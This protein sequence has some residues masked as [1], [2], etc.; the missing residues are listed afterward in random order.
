MSQIHPFVLSQEKENF[1]NRRRV[2]VTASSAVP[3]NSVESESCLN[4]CRGQKEEDRREDGSV[5]FVEDPDPGGQLAAAM[6]TLVLGGDQNVMVETAGRG[7]IIPSNR[8]LKVTVT[9]SAGEVVHGSAGGDVHAGA[10]HG[11]AGGDV[12]GSAVKKKPKVHLREDYTF[13]MELLQR[14][15]SMVET[16]KIWYDLFSNS[17][18]ARFP[19]AVSSAWDIGWNEPGKIFWC[20]PPFT[21]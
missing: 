10:A 8:E 14:V 19:D 18:T 16:T 13:R 15:V 9:G 4:G 6:E 11:G 7:C 17:L 12:H 21:Q 2:L 3:V 20:N 5:K 1:G